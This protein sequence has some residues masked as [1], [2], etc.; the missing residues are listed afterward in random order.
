MGHVHDIAVMVSQLCLV[1][2]RTLNCQTL[3]LG[4]RPRYNLEVA[5]DVKK[6]TNNNNHDIAK[7][8][9]SDVKKPNDFCLIS[10]ND[11]IT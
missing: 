5:E 8:L 6:P 11:F 3:C 9:T 1:C 10:S 4:A 7:F 2:G